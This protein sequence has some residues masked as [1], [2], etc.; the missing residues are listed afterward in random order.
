MKVV[1]I[2]AAMTDTHAGQSADERTIHLLLSERRPLWSS[3]LMGK[4]TRSEGACVLVN[5]SKRRCF[6]N[7][8]VGGGGLG[9]GHQMGFKGAI[10]SSGEV[11]QS[12]NFDIYNMNEVKYK[13]RNIYIP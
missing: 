7:R 6:K 2:R 3:L 5:S 9:E 11:I 8:G 4:T 1:D 10:C 13:L 12:Q